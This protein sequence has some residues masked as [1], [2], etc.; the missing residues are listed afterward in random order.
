MVGFG[1]DGCSGKPKETIK[2]VE[3]KVEV[4]KI[5][6]KIDPLKEAKENADSLAMLSGVAT[7]DLAQSI[8]SD[9]DA[10]KKRPNVQHPKKV[11]DK[12][13]GSLAAK[14]LGKVFRKHQGAMRKCYERQLKADPA[15]AGKVNLF[16]RINGTGKVSTAKASGL[17][18]K[19]HRCMVNEAKSMKFPAPDGGSV[20]VN[21]PYRFSPKT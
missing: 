2:K 13:T 19:V 21:K 9:M 4:K 8:A 11:S 7:S 5:E 10:L 3:K 20:S 14:D 16:V 17:S 15:L 1:C 18:S 12:D 6:V